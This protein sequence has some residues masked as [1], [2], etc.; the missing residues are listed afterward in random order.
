MFVQRFAC[1]DSRL[2]EL[3]IISIKVGPN[4]SLDSIIGLLLV[5]LRSQFEASSLSCFW[6]SSDFLRLSKRKEGPPKSFPPLYL[7]LSILF[8]RS[9]Q[10]RRS[11]SS[12]LTPPLFF[13]LPQRATCR[14]YL[15]RVLLICF[16]SSLFP[17]RSDH[18]SGN[19][20]TGSRIIGRR[21]R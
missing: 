11:C 8:F 12:V 14:L 16:A 7:R 10:S 19:I 4:F 9:S 3:L 6:W 2:P 5:L 21:S 20:G 13:D 17:S 1:G 18:H 15:R